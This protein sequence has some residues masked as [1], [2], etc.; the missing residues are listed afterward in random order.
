MYSSFMTQAQ[1][2]AFQVDPVMHGGTSGQGS[3][4]LPPQA[5]VSSVKANPTVVRELFRR[6]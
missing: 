5:E 1:T 2:A 4:S 3:G 6:I